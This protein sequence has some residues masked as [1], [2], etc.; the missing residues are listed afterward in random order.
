MVTMPTIS[1]LRGRPTRLFLYNVRF[2]YND[3]RWTGD[4][5]IKKFVRGGSGDGSFSQG[6]T[7]V[8]ERRNPV[9]GWLNVHDFAGVCLLV[10]NEVIARKTW[11]GGDASGDRQGDC[12]NNDVSKSH[13][14]F[15]PLRD[16]HTSQTADQP[17]LVVDP[18]TYGCWRE[19]CT[20]NQKGKRRTDENK[21]KAMFRMPAIGSFVPGLKDVRFVE[22]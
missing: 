14:H 5:A 10:L 21:N 11:V 16:A 17:T 20:G 13:G 6:A 9:G 18:T 15:S 4:A 12:R 8:N 22:Q 7:F 19:N 2:L 3:R 1:L